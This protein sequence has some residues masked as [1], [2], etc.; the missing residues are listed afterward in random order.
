VQE[1]SSQKI[2]TRFLSASDESNWLVYEITRPAKLGR[3]ERINHTGKFVFLTK[4]KA[5]LK[6]ER[7]LYIST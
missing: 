3:L 4:K 5:L 6:H 1:G 7:F 2:T